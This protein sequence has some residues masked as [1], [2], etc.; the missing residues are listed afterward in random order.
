MVEPRPA[1]VP[2]VFDARQWAGF[3]ALAGVSL[4]VEAA[5]NGARFT[6]DLLFTHRGLSGPAILQVSTYWEPGSTITLDLAPA[7]PGATLAD[8]LLALKRSSRQAL[9]SALGNLLPRRLAH[10]WHA[11]FPRHRFGSPN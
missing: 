3:A 10:G 8:A 1:L 5:C 4:E 7:A 6:E 2:L 9:G 11:A